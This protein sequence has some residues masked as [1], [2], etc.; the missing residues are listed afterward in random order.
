MC[1]QGLTGMANEAAE[2]LLNDPKTSPLSTLLRSL[3]VGSL[4]HI[5]IVIRATGLTGAP[6]KTEVVATRVR[7]VSGGTSR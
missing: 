3:P 5:E 1:L 6:V 2:Q 4:P 7:A